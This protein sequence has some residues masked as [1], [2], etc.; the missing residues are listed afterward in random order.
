MKLQPLRD[1][2]LVRVLPNES[3]T[4]GGLFIPECGQEHG[5]WS[6]C[7]VEAVGPGR[8]DA[9]GRTIPM[10]VA[11]GD[12][13]LTE[14]RAGKRLADDE[15]ERLLR[16]DEILGVFEGFFERKIFAGGPVEVD[17]GAA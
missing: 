9:E 15:A 10:L 17:G 16:S 12:V 5:R 1:D 14:W 4:P 2:V 7:Q 6:Y 13:V 8:L 11:I 3:K